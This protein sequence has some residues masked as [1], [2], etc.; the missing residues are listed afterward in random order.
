MSE[1]F[2]SPNHL[3]FKIF[4]PGYLKYVYSDILNLLNS[5]I[6]FEIMK[7]DCIYIVIVSCTLSKDTTLSYLGAQISNLWVTGI[8]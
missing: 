5:L 6:Y 8:T 2:V 4:Y 7:F 1:F 3:F